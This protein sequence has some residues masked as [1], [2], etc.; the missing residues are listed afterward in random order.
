M[1]ASFLVGASRPDSCESGRS[2][3]T[4]VD[5]GCARS[6]GFSRNS[7]LKPVLRTTP[8]IEIGRLQSLRRGF[9]GGKISKI[10]FASQD[11]IA[12]SLGASAGDWVKYDP[13]LPTENR[14]IAVVGGGISGL[15]AALRLRELSPNCQVTLFEAGPRPGGVLSTVHRD[16]YQVEQSADNFITTVPWGLELCQRLGLTGQLVQTNSAFR[17]TFVV[18]RG[19]G[20]TACPTAS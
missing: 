4:P 12:T 5:P 9:V 13:C 6:T 2:S 10:L 17:Q 16:G 19:S 1:A 20:C 14:R 15:A 11:E 3:V 18:R 8:G 7:R